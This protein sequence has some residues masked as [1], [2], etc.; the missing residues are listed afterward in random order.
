MLFSYQL[1]PRLKRTKYKLN[2]EYMHKACISWC[3]LINYDYKA[4]LRVTIPSHNVRNNTEQI[5]F[6]IYSWGA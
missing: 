6:G 2:P 4:A 3:I 1:L 5:R